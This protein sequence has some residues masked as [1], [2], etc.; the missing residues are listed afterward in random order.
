MDSNN[1]LPTLADNLGAEAQDL[2]RWFDKYR[3]RLRALVQLRLS[4]R[5]AGRFDASDVLQEAFLDATKRLAQ[6]R[7]QAN[8]SPYL[9]LRF[10]TL[11]RLG[12]FHRR[13]LYTKKRSAGRES[14]LTAPKISSIALADWIIDS[15]TSPSVSAFRHEQRDGL[16]AALNAMSAQDREILTARHFEQLSNEEAAEALGITAAAASR[17]YYRALERLR[18]IIAPFLGDSDRL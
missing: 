3:D 1:H 14:M 8:V 9:W 10:L 18:E 17:R 13:H 15:G 16:Q 11:Q 6:Y 4:S 12:I 2:N 5:L 7:N